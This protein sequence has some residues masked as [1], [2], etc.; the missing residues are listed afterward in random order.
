MLVW[1]IWLGVFLVVIS[2]FIVAYAFTRK[3]ISK[4]D[5]S[6]MHWVYFGAGLGLWIFALILVYLGIKIG[7]NRCPKCPSVK[8]VS[9]NPFKNQ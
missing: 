3:Q 4:D 6:D 5:V 2:S 9:V 1:L 7:I 8:A